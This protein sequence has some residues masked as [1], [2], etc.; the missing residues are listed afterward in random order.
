MKRKLVLS[1]AGL[2]LALSLAGCGRASTTAD[3][4]GYEEVVAQPSAS[5]PTNSVGMALKTNTSSAKDVYEEAEASSADMAEESNVSDNTSQVSNNTSGVSD[6]TSTSQ[7]SRKLIK[8][9]SID[10]E[11]ENLTATTDELKGKMEALGG[12]IESSN[13]ENGTRYG[14]KQVRK[15]SFTIRIPSDKLNEFTEFVGGSTHVVN[16]NENTEDVTLNYV[17][18]ESRKK[19]LEIEEERLLAIL[20]NATDLESIITLEERL[21]EIRYEKEN[22]EST[23]RTYDNLVDYS[24][25]YVYV[26]EVV[27]YTPVETHVDTVWERIS[28]GFVH[29]AMTVWKVLVNIFVFIVV[30]IPHFI[31]LG[32]IAAIITFFV[33]KANK[34]KKAKMQQQYA[35]MKAQVNSTVST[36]ANA[37]AGS[38]VSATANTQSDST[39]SASSDATEVKSEDK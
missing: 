38:S 34:K 26:T 6:N 13:I 25:V 2:M 18:V 35:S 9:V 20:E 37:Q 31:F 24:T 12:Y 21:A 17:D 5:G 36:P 4:S 3:S 33:K 8:T 14:N 27:E 7:S 23:L 10:V 30:N 28:K 19:S 15:A 29:S 32:L 22:I 39:V 1:L 16:Y 11:T